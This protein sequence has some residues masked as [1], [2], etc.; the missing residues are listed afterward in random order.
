M[1]GYVHH[2]RQSFKDS[3]DQSKSLFGKC[4]ERFHMFDYKP[5]LTPIEVGKRFE[6]V[7]DGENTTNQMEYHAAVGSLTYAS[8]ATRPGISLQ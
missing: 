2:E 6:K 4:A 8:I 3:N 1:S 7:K 5:V